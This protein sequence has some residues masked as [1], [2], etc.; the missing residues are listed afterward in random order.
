[1]KN[2]IVKNWRTTLLGLVLLFVA[3]VLLYLRTLTGGEFIALLPT[4]LGLLFM[5]DSVF[6][7][8]SE[9]RKCKM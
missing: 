5:P 4:I 3:I 6:G 1:M 8:R 7:R 2:R 9:N